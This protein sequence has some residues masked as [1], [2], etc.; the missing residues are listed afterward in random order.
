MRTEAAKF[1]TKF[2]NEHDIAHQDLE[3]I[4]DSSW[5]LGSALDAFAS[6]NYGADFD[7]NVLQ[8]ILKQFIE[9]VSV[10]RIATDKSIN[11]L[12]GECDKLLDMADDFSFHNNL[13]CRKGRFTGCDDELN[14]LRCEL[15]Q[16]FKVLSEA[17]GQA[18]KDL[19]G[20]QKATTNIGTVEKEFRIE[21]ELTCN[22]D[23]PAEQP[24]HS[25]QCKKSNINNLKWDIK[26]YYNEARRPYDIG[27]LQLNS[28]TVICD[29]LTD[30]IASWTAKLA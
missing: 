14:Q 26:N 7:L 1:F 5:M 11:H 17:A 3:V 20:I 18:E 19:R 25:C 15:S 12:Q 24:G 8:C 21:Y 23:D 9:I 6:A 10:R 2:G 16:F 30:A 22:Q 29:N 4:Q 13:T 27:R 28:L